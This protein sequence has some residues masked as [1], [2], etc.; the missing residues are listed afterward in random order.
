[1]LDI[2]RGAISRLMRK[3]RLVPPVLSMGT[4]AIVLDDSDRVLLV[5]H[6]YSPGWH[7]PGGT[8]E[9]GETVSANIRRELL[10]ETGV[11]L[12]Q[13]PKEILGVYYNDAQYKHDHVIVFIVRK[14]SMQEDFRRNLEV[15]EHKF[16]DL[17]SLPLGVTAGSERRIVE[18]LG[19]SAVSDRW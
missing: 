19:Q 14:W 9:A 6:T 4:K 11:S 13:E 10:E 5:K 18:L 3:L 1:M 16:F 8:V 17:H 7:F 2:L 15:R 12:A